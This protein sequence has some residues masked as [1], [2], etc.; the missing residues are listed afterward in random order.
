M[1]RLK[2][3][4]FSGEGKAGRT[5]AI[6]LPLIAQTFPEIRSCHPGTINLELESPLII[7]RPDH[8]TQPIKWKQNLEIG[9]VFDLVR[10]RLETRL[11]DTVHDAWLYIAHRS[12]HRKN[13]SHHELI[14]PFLK[15]DGI[16]EFVVDI[17]P[18]CV[19]L[20]YRHNPVY[21][22]T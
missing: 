19:Q 13:L 16:Q 7:V 14:A 17:M 4:R 6:Q 12:E 15:L 20:S 9:E 18:P 10:I 22:V 5:I 8:R 11:G 21:V 3:I 1:T 2:A